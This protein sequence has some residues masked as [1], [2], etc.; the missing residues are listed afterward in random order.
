MPQASRFRR[1]QFDSIESRGLSTGDQRHP[2]VF[3]AF[4]LAQQQSGLLGQGEA[5]LFT[6]DWRGDNTAAFFAAFVAFLHARLW[7]SAH[8]GGKSP[9]GAATSVSIC[10]R[11]VG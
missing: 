10:S 6:A 4:G 1:N 7:A 9:W 5:D 3:A 2:F 11:T 8:E